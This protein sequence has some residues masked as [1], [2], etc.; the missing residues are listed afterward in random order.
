MSILM[1]C[2]RI[3]PSRSTASD[4]LPLT[5]TFF[6]ITVKGPSAFEKNDDNV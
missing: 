4:A 6:N 2:V 5:R 1:S 3:W